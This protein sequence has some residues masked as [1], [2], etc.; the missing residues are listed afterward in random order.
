LNYSGVGPYD[1]GLIRLS[2]PLNFAQNVR[3]ISL[4]RAESQPIGDGFLAG[5]GSISR[6][7]FPNM[8]D[9][10]QH[11]QLPFISL[12]ACH[13]A[14]IRLTGSSP[15]HE[16]NLCTGPLNGEMSACSVSGA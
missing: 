14:V 2:S 10:L 12:Q 3:A 5:W 15:V 6:S 9:R 8:P 7:R 16:S 13:E 11:A 4:P 1:I